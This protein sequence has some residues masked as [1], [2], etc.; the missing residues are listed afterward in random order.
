M[1]A[2]FPEDAKLCAALSAYWPG[3][4]PDTARSAG[5]RVVAPM[6]DRE[7]G[8][9]KGAPAWDGVLGPRRVT[10]RGQDHVE[11]DNFDHVDYVTN[12]LTG[13][14]TMVETMK[15]SQQDYQTR[16]LATARMYRLIGDLAELDL[17]LTQRLPGVPVALVRPGTRRR[18]DD[19]RRGE[20]YRADLRRTGLP[21]RHGAGRLDRR[22]RPGSG[23]PGALAEAR[24]DLAGSPDRRGGAGG[25][26]LSDRR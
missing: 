6:T 8:L 4:A 24:A 7:V 20:G 16:V 14:F 26:C 11:T 19:R 15:V 9:V 2:R 18:R 1:A 23:Q 3:V 22:D 10:N 21:L 12:T 25:T 17:D 13:R 5:L